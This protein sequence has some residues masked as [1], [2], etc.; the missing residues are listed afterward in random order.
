MHYVSFLAVEADTSQEAIQAAESF[1]ESYENHA[2][3]WYVIGGRWSGACAGADFVCAG[4]S[5]SAFDATVETAVAAR[6]RHFNSVRQEIFGPDPRV[7]ISD[8]GAVSDEVTER[9]D[10][11][12]DSYRATSSEMLQIANKT[13]TPHGREYAMLGYC[14]RE[15]SDILTGCYGSNSYFY[16]TVAISNGT[17]FLYERVAARPDR[18]WLVVVDLHN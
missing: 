18:Q 2:Y 4:N 3:D 15:M 14:L 9:E 8:E 5:R 7:R 6:D 16:D 17:E 12:W 11:L 13:T 1:L 10:R